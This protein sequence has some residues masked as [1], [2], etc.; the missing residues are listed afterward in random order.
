VQS[1]SEEVA[2]SYVFLASRE[3]SSMSGQ[4]LQFAAE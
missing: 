1:G 4:T 3:S 2:A